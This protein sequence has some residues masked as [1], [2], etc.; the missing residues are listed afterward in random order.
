MVA[1]AVG[2]GGVTPAWAAAT[3]TV[4]SLTVTLSGS[5]ATVTAAI[6]ASPA[7]GASR[8]GVCV[9]TATGG[10]FDFP[11]SYNVSLTSTATTY[12]ASRTLP[13]GRYN[14]Y[15]CALVSG[16]WL[17]FGPSRSIVVAPVSATAAPTYTARSVAVTVKGTTATATAVVAS[18]PAVVAQRLAVCA[19]DAAGR[20]VDFPHALDRT[21]TTSGTAYTGSQTLPA[22][23]YLSSACVQVG[24]TWTLVGTIASF[25]VPVA[26][27]P[28][29]TPTPTP[30][31]PATPPATPSASTM[32]VGDL[33]GWRQVF[34]EDF[35]TPVP[36]G[37]FAT[38]V[39]GSRWF[40][41]SGYQ[42]TSG[43]GWYD[44]ARVISVK[45]GALD[46]YVHTADGKH[47]VAAMVP[48]VPATRW[49]QTYGRYSFRFR[50]DALPRYKFVAIL[51]PDSDN[52]GE[53]E[54]DFPE[55]NNLVAGNA[56][57]AN[58]Y[59][60]GNLTTKQPG[61]ANRFTTTV[62]A[63]GTGWHVA[64]IDWAPG[65]LTFYLDGATLGTFTQGVP[66]T[67]FH[68]VFQVET[69][70]HGAIPLDSTSGHLQVDWVTMYSRQ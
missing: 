23:S 2:V 9:R 8:L 48:R 28:T 47:R 62:D 67:S 27:A 30:T 16:A 26:T 64:T 45:D 11:H 38:S 21:L 49:G 37:S 66:S 50:S 14:A 24:G 51:W 10:N 61:P 44:P 13:A 4:T 17:S 35:L 5:T 29:P 69:D 3:P 41:Y 40:G 58:R 20:T 54:I 15:A 7:V 57:Y 34:T 25:T 12:R 39:Y 46:W 68:L 56:I 60:P 6:T 42:D 22:G 43:N 63:A 36:V 59:S 1:A 18:S 31:P 32:P 19:R 52:W 33:P 70:A 65:S 53:G 55:V